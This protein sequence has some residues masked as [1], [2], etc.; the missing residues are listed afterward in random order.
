MLGNGRT[1]TIASFWYTLAS[2]GFV[3]AGVGL[4]TKQQWFR[5]AM[6]WSAVLSLIA[7]VLLWD[8]RT[9]KTFEKG[10]LG[11]AINGLVIIA[12]VIFNWP[13]TIP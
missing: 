7:I 9:S 6:V 12:L 8:G 2:L 11:F 3:V 5:P 4:L 13:P 10:L 1:R